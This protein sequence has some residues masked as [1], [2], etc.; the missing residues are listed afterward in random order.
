MRTKEGIEASSATYRETTKEVAKKLKVD[1]EHSNYP[2]DDFKEII[3]MI[4]EKIKE[5][6]VKWYKM[7]I[8]RGL[9][10][11]TDM[12]LDGEIYKKGNTVYCPN[13]FE[14]RV[15]TKISGEQWVKRKFEIKAED[16]GF[17]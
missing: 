11:A 4:P 6:A 14:V 5:R 2:S 16:I 10:K 17:E 9:T 13:S 3:E 7:G 12:M 1:A 15:K 8:K